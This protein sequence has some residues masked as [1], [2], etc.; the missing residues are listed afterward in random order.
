[1]KWDF[2]VD[3]AANRDDTCTIGHSVEKVVLLAAVGLGPAHAQV[4]WA[5]AST[6]TPPWH[7]RCRLKKSCG[8]QAQ[9]WSRGKGAT[10]LFQPA[11]SSV[12]KETGLKTTRRRR[13]TIS[14]ALRPFS[15][16]TRFLQACR[17]PMHGG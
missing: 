4:L 13:R 10:S 16:T 9:S 5:E 2:R 3:F 12:T 6:W 17:S 15:A 14:R 8:E 1:M 11:P 7:R